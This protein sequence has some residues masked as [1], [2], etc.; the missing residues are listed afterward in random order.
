VRAAG[1]RDGC[2]LWMV[3]VLVLCHATYALIFRQP[4]AH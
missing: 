2:V 1:G 3:L 4:A